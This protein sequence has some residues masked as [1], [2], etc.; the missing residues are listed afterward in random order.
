MHVCVLVFMGSMYVSK[1]ILEFC[2]YLKLHTMY[3]ICNMFDIEYCI[4]VCTSYKSLHHK[5][6]STFNRS[7]LITH[8]QGNYKPRM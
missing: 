5:S 7:H 2:D 6:G 1:I 3:C 8:V 4:Y